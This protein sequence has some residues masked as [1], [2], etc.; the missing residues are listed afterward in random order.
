MEV[1]LREVVEKLGS[2]GQVVKVAAGFARNFLLPQ[3]LAVAASSANLKIVAQEKEA[4]L[5]REAKAQ[6]EN[7]E[8]AKLLSAVTIEIHQKAGENDHL[9]G[10][11]ITAVMV[12]SGLTLFGIAGIAWAAMKSGR[13]KT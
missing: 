3:R 11:V 9:F 7:Q 10:S 12:F 1:I 5:K 8:L 2:R 13:S 4:H 6:V